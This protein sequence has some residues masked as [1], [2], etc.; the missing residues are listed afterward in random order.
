MGAFSLPST[1][2]TDLDPEMKQFCAMST[3]TLYDQPQKRIRLIHHA[4]SS[5][6]N[7]DTMIYRRFTDGVVALAC[8]K[9]VLRVTMRLVP[10]SVSVS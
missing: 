6:L 2:E 5:F 7:K 1:P 10:F 8:A 9:L 3:F 4:L